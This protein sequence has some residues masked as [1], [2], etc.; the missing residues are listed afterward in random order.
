MDYFQNVAKRSLD[1]IKDLQGG[2]TPPAPHVISG[3]TQIH[4]N[5]VSDDTTELPESI[6]KLEELKE[7]VKTGYLPTEDEKLLMLDSIRFAPPAKV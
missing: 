4:G 7:K 6:K 1:T 2:G 5:I 3:E